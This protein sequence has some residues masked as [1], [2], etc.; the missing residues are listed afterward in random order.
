MSRD[1]CKVQGAIIT[2]SL[3]LLCACD[4]GSPSRSSGADAGLVNQSAVPVVCPT[5]TP[6]TPVFQ[7][8]IQ[9]PDV[10][11]Y[12]NAQDL[13]VATAELSRPLET[14]DLTETSYHLT[15]GITRFTTVD[16]RERVLEFYRDN[17]LR[18]G[19]SIVEYRST[20]DRLSFGWSVAAT[21]SAAQ[22]DIPC[23]PTPETGLPSHGLDVMVLGTSEG[24]RVEL[25]YIVYPGH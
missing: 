11:E 18:A 5:S 3:L 12:P 20:D 13:Q 16:S 22:R 6:G 10:P 21:V 2:I 23:A 9:P 25:K 4:S 8:Q 1:A 15:K 14:P 17:L 19:W 7:S 24:T